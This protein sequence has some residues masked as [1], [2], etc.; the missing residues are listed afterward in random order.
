MVTR[1]GAQMRTTRR[2]RWVGAMV[3]GNCMTYQLSSLYAMSVSKGRQVAV[4][5]G[6]SGSSR[7]EV[8][9]GRRQLSDGRSESADT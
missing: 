6:I 1:I 4:V 9:G 3:V 8:R 5:A 7:R 2:V